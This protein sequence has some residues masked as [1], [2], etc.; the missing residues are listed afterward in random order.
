MTGARGSG[1][2]RGRADPRKKVILVGI[3]AVCV[4]FAAW[5]II[6]TLTGGSPPAPSAAATRE[7]QLRAEYERVAPKDQAPPDEITPEELDPNRPPPR[8]PRDFSGK[9]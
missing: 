3:V 4:G 6:G 7:A 9:P 8:A 1:A 2:G 5:R